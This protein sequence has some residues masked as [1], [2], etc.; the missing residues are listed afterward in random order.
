[1][2]LGGYRA[3]QDEHPNL[4]LGCRDGS[5]VRKGVLGV[6]GGEGPDRLTGID[7]EGG[8]A[9]YGWVEGLDVAWEGP[10]KKMSK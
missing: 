3:L 8:C 7:P 10:P 2:K 6:G 9:R 1:M 5:R 4:S